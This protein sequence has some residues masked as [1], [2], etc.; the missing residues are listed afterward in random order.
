MMNFRKKNQRGNTGKEPISVWI[1]GGSRIFSRKI[2]KKEIES[3]V[4]LFSRST[5][6][7]FRTLPNHYKDPILAEFCA[8]QV[9]F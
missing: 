1:R 3:F 2:F 7:I 9:K 4:D 8:L 6:L 5:K